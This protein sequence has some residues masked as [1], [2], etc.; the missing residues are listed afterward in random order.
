MTTLPRGAWL[1]IART[2]VTAVIVDEDNGSDSPKKNV[3]LLSGT[4][5]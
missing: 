4:C 3:K 2:G 1:E 5:L